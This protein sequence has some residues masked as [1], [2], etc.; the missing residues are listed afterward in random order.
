[1]KYYEFILMEKKNGKKS[2]TLDLHSTILLPLIILYHNDLT[3]G[4]NKKEISA[5]TTILIFL[6]LHLQ[7][8]HHQ[9]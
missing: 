2:D 8:L 7:P 9:I 4:K 5:I 6:S 3:W 1:M